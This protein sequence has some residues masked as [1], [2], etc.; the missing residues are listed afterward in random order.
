VRRFPVLDRA[1]QEQI[2]AAREAAGLSQRGLSEIL[3]RR[4]NYIQ[5]IESGG[6]SV[7]ASELHVIALA[8]DSSGPEL[9]ARAIRAAKG[10]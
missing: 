6:Q 7:T 5:N 1:I 8:C 3:K 9:L 4:N 10:K 2:A